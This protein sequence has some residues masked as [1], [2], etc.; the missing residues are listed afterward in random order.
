MHADE[1]DIDIPLLR[2]LL[3]AQFPQWSHLSIEPVRPLGTD[4]ALFK[5]GEELVVRLPRRDRTSQ[6]LKKELHWLPRLAPKLP[7]PIPIPKA[8]GTP[9]EGYPFEWSVYTWLNGE[10]AIADRVA[11][12]NQLAIDVAGFL[13]ALQKIDPTGGPPP[14]PHNFYR[15]APL[16]ARDEMTHTAITRLGRA[17]DGNAVTAVWEAA[18]R[19]PQWE[20]QPVW[21]HGDLDPLNVLVERGRL[22]AIIDFGG[23]GLGDPACDVMA[24]WKLFSSPARDIFR[25]ELSV[26]DST[27][28]RSRGWAL[29][30]AVVA[31]S[32]Y[33]E[34]TNPALIREAR[35]WITEILAD[36]VS[37]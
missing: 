3:A 28:M 17:I 34:E 10:N 29:S 33:T 37:A 11:D 20:R 31:L 19:A 4:N 26:D 5:L 6:T 15:G 36:P 1:V 18:L 25:T 32:Y 12:L 7:L 30:Q 27:W 8:T 23:L 21:I 24:A 22:C 2:R 9:A 35:R 16:I 13:Q 14:G